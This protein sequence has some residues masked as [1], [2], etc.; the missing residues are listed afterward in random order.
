[1]SE[2]ELVHLLYDAF[3]KQEGVGS[4]F[5]EFGDSLHDAHID[6]DFDLYEVAEAILAALKRNEAN[7]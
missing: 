4:N 7:G 2:D 6:G 1:M 3:K 5:V